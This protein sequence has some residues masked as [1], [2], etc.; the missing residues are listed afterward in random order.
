MS[1][2]L[3]RGAVSSPHAPCHPSVHQEVEPAPASA[4][5]GGQEVAVWPSV[6]DLRKRFESVEGWLLFKKLAKEMRDLL[7]AGFDL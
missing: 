6:S 5:I 3:H 7:A 1:Y 4:V 2:L